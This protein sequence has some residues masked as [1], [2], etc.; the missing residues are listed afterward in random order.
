MMD[1]VFLD[2]VCNNP[3][4]FY[5]VLLMLCL[6]FISFRF[7]NLFSDERTQIMF[8]K[9]EGYF[10][11]PGLEVIVNIMVSSRGMNLYCDL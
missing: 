5:R 2:G 9:K 6:N 1:R 8:F 4:C 11:P 7:L 3:F 10:V